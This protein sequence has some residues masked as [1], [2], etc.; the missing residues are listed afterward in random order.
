LRVFALV[1]AMMGLGPVFALSRH[2]RRERMTTFIAGRNPSS[3]WDPCHRPSP[4]RLTTV[5]QGWALRYGHRCLS[6]IGLSVAAN[7]MFA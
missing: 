7:Q 2:R 4:G 3:A 5:G 6:I 1:I